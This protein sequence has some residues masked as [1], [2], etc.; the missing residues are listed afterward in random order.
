M[1]IIYDAE[2]SK[3]LTAAGVDN[4]VFLVKGAV[5]G[6]F[7]TPGTCICLNHMHRVSWDWSM[8]FRWCVCLILSF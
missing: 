5:H 6:Y 7:T 3:R 8:T 2:Y 1:R 4:E